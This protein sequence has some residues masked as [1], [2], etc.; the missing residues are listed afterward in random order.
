MRGWVVLRVTALTD[1]EY[2]LSSVALGIDEYYA[3][4][5][6]APGV[7][8]GGWATDLAVEGMVEADQLRAL[9][10][11]NHPASGA[12]LSAGLRERSVKAV[13]LTFSAPKSVSLLW[14]L[15]S[16]PVADVVMGAHRDAVEVAL[17]FLEEHAATAR[18]QAEGIRRHVGTHGW[19]VAGFVHRTSR[20][21]DPQLHTHSWSPT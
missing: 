4:V 15:G 2:L 10:G 7:W 8:S 5:G 18:I 13:D 21:G 20:E 6:E 16:E 11:G 1:G 19:V 14:A 3:G 17:G 9:I 12:P